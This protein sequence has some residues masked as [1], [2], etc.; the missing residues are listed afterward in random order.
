MS[1]YVMLINWTEQGMKTIGDGAKRLDAAKK[2]LEDMGGQFR[3][4]YMTMGQFDMVGVY[5]APDDAVAA[6]YTMM[7]GRLGN[8]RTTSMKAFPEE[9]YRQIVNSLDR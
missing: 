3:A 5:D 4:L 8:V 7:L 6:R 9:A 2:M 1:T